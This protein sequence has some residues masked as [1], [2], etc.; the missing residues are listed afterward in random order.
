MR[1]ITIQP[2]NFYLL[3]WYNRMEHVDLG[4]PSA[5]RTLMET[6]DGQP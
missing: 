5:I 3:D 6:G 4:R 2:D 1:Q